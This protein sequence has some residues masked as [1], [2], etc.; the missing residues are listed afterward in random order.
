[1]NAFL[2]KLDFNAK[3][4]LY[5]Q[6]YSFLVEEIKSGHLKVDERLP[7]KK[8]VCSR[9]GISQS[10][11]ETAYDMLLAEG[12]IRSIPRS[13]YYVCRLE[14]LEPSESFPLP[15][16][17]LAKP[18]EPPYRYYFS[19]SAVDTKAFP[20]VSWAKLHKEVMY[21]NPEL[22]QRGDPQGDHCLRESLCQ[23]L[24][25]YRGVH[26][27][28][29]QIVVGAGIEYLLDL[30]LQLL[31]Q[32][33]VFALENPG[34]DT[35][36][37]II[38][39]NGRSVVDIPLDKDGM[40]ITHLAQS[41]ATVAYVT[42]S[43]QFPMGITMPIGRRT[44]LLKWASESPDRYIIEDD[45]DSEF[46]FNIRPIPAMQG[47]SPH[48]KVIYVGTFSRSIAPSIRVAYLVLPPTLLH[49]YLEKFTFS[50]STVSR[51]EQHTLCR[52]L[53]SGLFSRH[54]NRV[55]NLYKQRKDHTIKQLGQTLGSRMV[56]QGDNAGLHFLIQIKNGMEESELVK[57]ALKQGVK[58]NGLSRYFRGDVRQCPP[59]TLVMGYAG[60]CRQELSDAVH[61]LQKAWS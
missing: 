26:C 15:P 61:L 27:S 56:I 37:H 57:R 7:S 14:R 38:R 42:P 11:V 33:A 25:E 40:S 2:C 36:Y 12:Y 35:T 58:I 60:L 51:F 59:S 52:F 50:S 20:Y 55:G 10:T 16:I 46:R 48:G 3:R 9:L 17:P 28:P 32:D 1:M 6:L 19:T 24:R 54:L 22:L 47:L 8:S 23:F 39:N 18:S 31:E 49:R 43:H 45:Y 30:V 5:L 44:Q 21:Q 29:D 13:G 4:P 41:G 53:E 34:Y